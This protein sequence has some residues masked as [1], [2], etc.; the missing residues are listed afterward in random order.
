MAPLISPSRR[1][2][3]QPALRT[4]GLYPG[5]LRATGR[6][7]TVAA[8]DTG[9][10]TCHPV[11]RG[12][13][14]YRFVETDPQAPEDCATDATPVVPGFGHG[15]AVASLIRVTAPEAAIWAMRVFDNTG[16]ALTSDV[17]E[18]IVFAADHGVHVINMSFGIASPSLALA[19][20][21]AYAQERGAVLVAAGG[22]SGV[23]PLMHPAA[24]PGVK[25]VVSTTNS[26]LKASFSSYG[27]ET[28]VSAPGYGLWV[29][30]P[31]L[32]LKYVAGT[33]Y[34]SPL[35]AG[36]AALIIDA[37]HRIQSGDP[38]SS[39]I[40]D[41]MLSGTVAIDS[42]NPD[43]ALK[44]GRGRIYVPWALNSTGLN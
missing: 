39:M 19:D 26:D 40:N 28:F 4:I 1:L 43:Y 7:L 27:L 30:F 2:L 41:S 32:K 3:L 23:E 5:V 25:G 16:T 13:V 20:A 44:L 22:N 8:L 38:T 24:I 17:Y 42:L 36:E 10:D 33:S 9:A 31:N 35:V 34:S 6:G 11:L 18:A 37:Y 29:A 15:T 12:I 21:V 14:T